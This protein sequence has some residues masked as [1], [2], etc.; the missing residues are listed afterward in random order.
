[1][2]SVTGV[3]NRRA[4]LH[5]NCSTDILPLYGMAVNLCRLLMPSNRSVGLKEFGHGGAFTQS[6]ESARAY[7]KS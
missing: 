6:R 3:N 4:T 5:L 2:C 1:M 7:R